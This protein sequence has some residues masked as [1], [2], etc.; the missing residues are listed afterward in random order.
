MNL[1]IK[2][3]DPHGI[4][5]GLTRLDKAEA[6]RIQNFVVAEISK[7]YAEFQKEG[8]LDGQY[9]NRQTGET[10]GSVRFFKLKNGR[11]GVAP[12]VGVSGN[13]NYLAIYQRGGEIVPQNAKT[14]FFEIDG[15]PIF[16]RSVYID[17]KPFVTD[18]KKDYESS[19]KPVIIM[20]NIWT[21]VFQRKGLV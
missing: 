10:A 8:Y 21:Q 5:P 7:N 15:N 4:I 2:I 19:D 1:G 3:E 13:L 11:F 17:P 20:R 9:L 14:L 6:E 18:S 12:G 16:A